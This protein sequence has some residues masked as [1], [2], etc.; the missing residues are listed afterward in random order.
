MSLELRGVVIASRSFPSVPMFR[1]GQSQ[2][3]GCLKIVHL[4]WRERC[5]SEREVQKSKSTPITDGTL[6]SPIT[7]ISS[8]LLYRKSVGKKSRHSNSCSINRLE[9]LRRKMSHLLQQI[10][11][12]FNA[13]KFDINCHAS[14]F[15]CHY[16]I[17]YFSSCK[18]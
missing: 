6:Q 2:R 18:V 8:L 3:A 5:E 4:F 15:L 17:L 7:L 10:G 16:C 14:S 9:E 11:T 12:A 1:S 13:F